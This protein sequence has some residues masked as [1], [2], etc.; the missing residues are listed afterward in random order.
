MFQCGNLAVAT[1]RI[2]ILTVLPILSGFAQTQVAANPSP[3]TASAAHADIPYR[4][5]TFSSPKLDAPLQ[6]PFTIMDGAPTCSSEGYA[7]YQ[8]WTARSSDSPRAIVSVSPSGNLTTYSLAQITGLRF[9]TVL[10]LDSG[11]SRL[12]LLLTAKPADASEGAHFGFY[13]ARFRYDGRLDGVSQLKVDFQPGQLAQLGDDS[14]IVMGTD[15]SKAQPVVALV[16]GSGE[17]LR[18][19]GT[20]ALIPS[21]SALTQMMAAQNFVGIKPDAMPPAQRLFYLMNIFRFIH[22]GEDLLL[23]EPGASAKIVELLPDAEVRTIALHIPKGQVAESLI[24][25][26]GKWLIR[27]HRADADDQESMFQIDPADGEADLGIRTG[28]VPPTTIACAKQDGFFGLRWIDHRP[29]L[30]SATY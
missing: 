11:S 30:I 10:G 25:A 21:G 13:L 19:L 23:L 2:V 28:G 29:Y 24:A 15:L 17:I 7:F 5:M 26:P 27:A 9:T 22:F 18:R 8:F 4:I 1:G 16:D 12:T 20:D 14:Y 6:L 3:D